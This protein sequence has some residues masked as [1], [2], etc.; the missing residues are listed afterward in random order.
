[1]SVTFVT[2][3][4]IVRPIQSSRKSPTARSV[5]THYQVKAPQGF[6]N[7][8][9]AYGSSKAF[10]IPNTTCPVCGSSVF[11]YQ[12][13]NGARVYF[14]ELGPPW[15]KHP[16]TSSIQTYQA[17]GRKPKPVIKKT[18][19]SWKSSYWQ[20]LVIK[21]KVALPSNN[22]VRIE[23]ASDDFT[24]RFDL[25]SRLLSEKQ[26]RPEDVDHLVMLGRRNSDSRI[27]LSITSGW[28]SWSMFG[29][30]VPARNE[31]KPVA[32]EPVVD[33]GAIR[34]DPKGKE[35]IAFTVKNNKKSA[36]FKFIQQEK[37]YEITKS[38]RN[39]NQLWLKDCL[40]NVQLYVEKQE[41]HFIV[42]ITDEKNFISQSFKRKSAIVQ[43]SKKDKQVEPIEKAVKPLQTYD[44]TFYSLVKL[45]NKSIFIFKDKSKTN[46][47]YA[48]DCDAIKKMMT[49]ND[50]LSSSAKFQLKE[51]PLG[52][53]VFKFG[54]SLS[55]PIKVKCF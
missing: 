18:A 51:T 2:I 5:S 10:T 48:I 46:I 16:C 37:A 6:K 4:G 39:P 55:Q 15:T 53:H 24:V 50:L 38:L 26:C 25:N 28:F 29:E 13:P 12:H 20:P 3:D 36:V 54:K 31:S 32:A 7:N 35:Q 9:D 43:T 23:A 52:L 33:A 41:K 27:E 17:K 30:R 34:F 11:Y 47:S 42:F 8:K 1:M 49:L 22:G 44:V 40:D 45:D 19:D 14:E 21:Q